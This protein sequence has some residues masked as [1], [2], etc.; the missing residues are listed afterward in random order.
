VFATSISIKVNILT[1]NTKAPSRLVKT[2][3]K[4]RIIGRFSKIFDLRTG[5]GKIIAN[6]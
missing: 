3:K 6:G 2:S 4:V 5:D 1:H